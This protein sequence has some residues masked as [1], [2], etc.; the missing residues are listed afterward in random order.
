MNIY[1]FDVPLSEEDIFNFTSEST[2]YSDK[3]NKLY[4]A[5]HP[6]KERKFNE[7]PYIKV[8]WQ[9]NFSK[10]DKIARLSLTN[11]KD[12]I[13]HY[14]MSASV[15]NKIAN[16]IN[17]A[18]ASKCTDDNVVNKIEKQINKELETRNDLSDKE[19][20]EIRDKDVT[21]WDAI[22]YDVYAEDQSKPYLQLQQEF[23]PREY[24]NLADPKKT[25]MYKWGS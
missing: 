13:V 17:K 4:I 9:S 6:D 3:R 21:Y 15:P 14:H 10:N 24:K 12:Y 23:P 20:K 5:V 7:N 22:L 11:D 1:E 8:S 19:K 18:L 2:V 16:Q 25:T